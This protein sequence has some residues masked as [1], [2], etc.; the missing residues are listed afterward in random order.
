MLKT[1][2]LWFWLSFLVN[3]V[4]SIVDHPGLWIGV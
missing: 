2:S 1:L 4:M 3:T